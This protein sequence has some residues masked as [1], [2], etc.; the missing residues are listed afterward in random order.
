MGGRD[1]Q[2]S[3]R[4]FLGQVKNGITGD[5]K[6]KIMTLEDEGVFFLLPTTFEPTVLEQ[7]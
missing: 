1:L 4:L 7:K 6:V 3:Q 5:K 2:F